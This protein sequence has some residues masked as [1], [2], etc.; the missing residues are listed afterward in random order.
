MFGEAEKKSKMNFNVADLDAIKNFVQ[1]ITK[2]ANPI[3]KI[4]DFLGDDV[5]SMNKE[6][7]SWIRESKTYKDRYDEEVR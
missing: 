2:N 6:L 1:D 3:G 5:E 7:Q 4:I